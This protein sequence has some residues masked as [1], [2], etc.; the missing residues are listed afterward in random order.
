MCPD[1]GRAAFV[2]CAFGRQLDGPGAASPSATA[3]ASPTPEAVA[4]TPV[5]VAAAD[6]ALVGDVLLLP[7]GLVLVGSLAGAPAIWTSSDGDT[8]QIQAEGTLGQAGH[9]AD[10]TEHHG[11]VLA[12]GWR[13][14]QQ[15]GGIADEPLVVV[16]GKGDPWRAVNG[17]P[18]PART[19]AQL[20]GIA[21]DGGRTQRASQR[22]GQ[23]RRV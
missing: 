1:G 7:Q 18:L 20:S 3:E 11:L 6:D 14:V 22:A 17:L 23:F 5:T 19:R 12:V 8:W 21:T 10:L 2:S 16:G 13:S 15:S 4:P 9:L